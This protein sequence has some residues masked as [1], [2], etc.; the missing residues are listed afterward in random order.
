MNQGFQTR[1]C[2]TPAGAPLSRRDFPPRGSSYSELTR[3]V[4]AMSMARRPNTSWPCSNLRSRG[5]MSSYAAI[6]PKE[7]STPSTVSRA[8][9]VARSRDVPVIV[10]RKGRDFRRYAGATVITPNALEAELATSIPCQDDEGV[11]EAARI[12]ADIVGCE[13]VIITRGAQGMTVLSRRNGRDEIAHLPTEAREV[14]DVSGAGDTVTAVLALALAVGAPLE[15]TARLANIGAG[16]AVGKAGTNPVEA[17]ELVRAVEISGLVQKNSKIVPL[18]DA[19]SA[20]RAWRLHNQRVVFTNGC[21]DLLHPGHVR[22]LE[23]ARAYGDKLIVALNSDDLVKRLKGPTRPIQTGSDR[24]I[25]MA[26]ISVV[27]LVTIFT[28]DTPLAAIQAI[29]PDVLVK[30]ADYTEDEVVGA[31]IV[32]AYGGRIVLVPLEAGQSTTR[33]IVR[34]VPG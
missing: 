10:D 18:G 34:A 20:A 9:N 1:S 14:Y 27:D 5:C 24:A 32:H 19:I 8:I 17:T 12:I 30:G 28:E 2:E 11:T 23:K 29:R 6:M 13:A 22:L 21:F 15:T 4:S 33:A 7:Y 31:E 26:S 16:L 25:V 3:K